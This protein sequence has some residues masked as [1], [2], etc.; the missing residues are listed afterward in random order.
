MTRRSLLACCPACGAC[1]CGPSL[2]AGSS[3]R[4]SIPHNWWPP[5]PACSTVRAQSAGKNGAAASSAASSGSQEYD[6][7]L[8]IIGCGV[9]GHGAAL[10]AVECVSGTRAPQPGLPACCHLPPACCQLAQLRCTGCV[11]CGLLL[12]DALLIRLPASPCAPPHGRLL[13]SRPPPPVRV[14]AA[15]A[16]SAPLPFHSPSQPCKPACLCTP[17]LWPHAGRGRA[18]V[19]SRAG[20]DWSTPPQHPRKH[21]PAYLLRH[22][23]PAGPQGGHCGGPRHRRHLR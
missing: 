1:G 6:Y 8:L 17:P 11:W 7:D 20:P 18:S 14:H 4:A 13:C 2:L 9:G 3:D 16:R 19:G 21:Q 15:C 10:H 22:R 12:L 23:A 5:A